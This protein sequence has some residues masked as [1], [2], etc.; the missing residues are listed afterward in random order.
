MYDLIIQNGN[1]IDGTG[2]PA[3]VSD[4]AIKGGKIV[5][6]APNLTGGKESIDATGLTVTPGFIDSHSHS[7]NALKDYPDV[8]EKIEQG[9]TTS[10][11]GQCGG[12][13][14]PTKEEGMDAFLDTYKDN[15]YGSNTAILVGHSNLRRVVIGPGDKE[16]SREEMEAMK[17]LLR[18]GLEHGALGLSFGLI[19][20]PGCYA[21]TPELIELAKVVKEYD[22]IIV[23]HI[24]NEGKNVVEATAEFIEVARQSG[25]RAVV[26]HHKSAGGKTGPDGRKAN[27]G[28]VKETLKMIEEANQEGI[29]IYCDV[30]PYIA[31]HTSMFTTFMPKEYRVGGTEG[32]IEVLSNP[33]MRER[34]KEIDK[35]IWGEEADLSW[36]QVA[37]CKG[38]PEYEGMRVNEIAKLRGTDVYDAVFDM[39]RDSENVC[40]ACYFTMCE[41]DVE[42]VMAYPRTMIGTDASV[43]KDQNVYHPRTRGTFPRTLGRYVRERH[44]T[45]LE[46]MI[47]K[48]TSL[49]A[50]VYELHTKGLIKEGMD[51][52][53]CI[54]DADRIIDHASFTACH[55]RAEGLNY[56]ILG[57]EV[58]VEDAIYN[59]KRKGKLLLR[60]E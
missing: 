13:V 35:A 14:A 59:G 6:I 58:V 55:E 28:K 15:L 29:E 48:M 54:F 3:F 30:Y 45:S 33:E 19:Y 23:A 37:R 2:K 27:W 51:A 38:Y 41:E 31:T 11:S 50:S 20:S 57:G 24:R 16:P 42:T 5:R 26:S 46:E 18:D 10:I 52:D 39:I 40:T 8:M 53:L 22:G 4:V 17:A 25:T 12:S 9:I 56:V 7:D 21:K 47:R 32:V 60:K 36:I 49:P 34:I 1:I 43:A 44:V